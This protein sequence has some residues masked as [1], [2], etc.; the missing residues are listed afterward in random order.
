MDQSS[1]TLDINTNGMFF[2][3]KTKKKKLTFSE[4][5]N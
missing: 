5:F 1:V 4:P 3:N 2:N